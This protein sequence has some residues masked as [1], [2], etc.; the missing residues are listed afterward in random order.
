MTESDSESA[1]EA[2]PEGTP[3]EQPEQSEPPRKRRWGLVVAAVVVAGGLGIWFGFVR[4]WI[5]SPDTLADLESRIAGLESGLFIAESGRGDLRAELT[6]AAADAADLLSRLDAIEALAAEASAAAQGAA[7]LAAAESLQVALVDLAGRLQGF[8]ANLSAALAA[9]EQFDGR[10]AALEAAASVGAAAEGAGLA[11]AEM[12]RRVAELER[13]FAALEVPAPAAAAPAG[14]E[15]FAAALAQL[16]ARLSALENGVGALGA[17][18]AAQRNA[19]A[20]VA[21][22]GQLR[23]AL[24][25][26]A[27]FSPELDA[28]REVARA[29]G[30]ADAELLAAASSLS[31]FAAAG[32]ATVEELAR[33][34]ATVAGDVVA[35][36]GGPRPDGWAGALWERALSLVRLRRTGEVPG[37]DSEA[38]VARAEL[39]IA[40][41]DLAAAVAEIE[42]LEGPAA[43]AAAAWLA[44][45]RD[46]LAADAAAERIAS[47]ALALLS[48]SP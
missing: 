4:G 47:R 5:T 28:L 26:A 44:D 33:R 20:L 12:T 40:A 41:G 2:A 29:H 14:V 1:Q 9:L 38:R 43:D 45:A 25:S 32:V 10:I 6:A 46:R 31:S 8:A 23:E 21:A 30:A 48:A 16:D 39:R 7:P 15:R 18:P 11:V 35:A 17:G 13:A 3:P 24:R 27:P 37:E 19:A 42:G 22:A 34:F 36:T